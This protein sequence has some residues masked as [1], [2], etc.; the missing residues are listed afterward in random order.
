[1][2]KKNAPPHL[3]VV[4]DDPSALTLIG[5]MIESFGYLVSTATSGSKAIEAMRTTP[6]D[7]VITD[8]VMPDMDGL[9]LVRHIRASH[10]TTCA[11]IITGFTDRTTFS[12]V[13]ETGAEDFIG[14]PVHRGE[15]QARIE[16]ILLQ[17]DIRQQ[18][19]Q[20]VDQQRQLQDEA[21]RSLE[22]VSV[23]NRLLNL[24]VERK[25]LDEI[26]DMFIL[27]ITS[28]PWLGLSPKGAI[29]LVEDEPDV[30]VMKAHHNLAP[31]LIT[32][33][34]T[35]PSGRCLCGQAA[36]KKQ[37]VFVNHLADDHHI[38][39]DGIPDHGHYCVPILAPDGE[40]L[41][42]FTL[43]VDAGATRNDQ[44][45]ET[46][47]A[48]AATMAGILIQHRT[49]AALTESE[50]LH[51]AITDTASDGIILMDETGK[52]HFWNPAAQKIFGFTR[53]EATGKPLHQILTHTPSTAM[54]NGIDLFRQT[55]EGAMVG[56]TVELEGRH[57]DGRLVTVEL[58]LSALSIKNHWHALGIVRDISK[59]KHAEED[60]SRL[61]EELRQ[62]Q[63]LKAV[64]TM[65]SGLAH[66]F[67]NILTTIQGFASLIKEDPDEASQV[68]ED[69]REILSVTARGIEVVRKM[70]TLSREEESVFSPLKI[71]PVVSET[72]N[73][74][75]KNAPHGIAIEEQYST[76]DDTVL[77]R[78]SEIHEVVNALV[79]NA[80]NAMR[81][82]GGT[83]SV[84]LDAITLT[85]RPTGGVTGKL[86]AGRWLRLMISDTGI[87]MTPE[88]RSR[89]FDPYFS[90]SSHQDGTGLGLTVAYGIVKAMDGDIVVESTFG[91]GSTFT[92]Y[93][94]PSDP[95]ASAAH[96]VPQ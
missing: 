51:K 78:A 4:D 18:L 39:F 34:A 37:V 21:K 67:N 16:R 83:L 13:I 86:Q 77:G 22:S 24:A 95:P 57:K 11:A 54:H 33:C 56:R 3:L 32:L 8:L 52:I 69:A 49:E 47:K 44:V 35:V 94:P 28:L 96:E 75:K 36:Q 38:T 80:V 17:R 46:L 6:F 26:L 9:D 19:T 53:R 2:P 55:G 20:T 10:P 27:H 41:G 15:L 14:K 81:Q 1:M 92:L 65:A 74:L 29:L 91:K 42:V 31:E 25:S 30:L 79:S 58:S 84:R 66:E 82:Q 71:T 64:S 45:E 72:L 89:I 68:T 63:K 90:A 88:T 23:L 40:L 76:E 60:R 5:R 70:Q 7:V 48:A 12:E 85:N 50:R 61:Q 62:A 73:A 43:Y 87:G 59:R 93:L